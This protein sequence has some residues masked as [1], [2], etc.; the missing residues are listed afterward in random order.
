MAKLVKGNLVDMPDGTTLALDEGEIQC[1][2]CKEI[3]KVGPKGFAVCSK[4]HGYGPKNEIHPNGAWFP[5]AHDAGWEWREG[6]VVITAD[7]PTKGNVD[8]EATAAYRW[9]MD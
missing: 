8:K 2:Y 1:A 3:V 4:G 9:K 5:R 6:A 7:G